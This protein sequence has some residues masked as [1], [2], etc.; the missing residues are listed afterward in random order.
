VQ[1]DRAVDGIRVANAGSVGAFYE[2]EPAAY[3]AL[4]GS[5][6]ELGRT[7]YDVGADPDRPDRLSALIEGVP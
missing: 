7:D 2:A 4:L 3:W 5:D 1:F 6:V